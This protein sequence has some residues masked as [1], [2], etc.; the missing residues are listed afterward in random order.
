MEHSKAVTTTLIVNEKFSKNDG[1]RKVDPS[2][3]RSL[4][5]SLMYLTATRPDIMFATSMLSRF[6]NEPSE[7]HMGAVKRVLRYLKGISDLGILYQA[8]SNPRLVAYLDSDWGVSIDDMKSTTGYAFSFGSGVFSWISKKQDIV[9]KS[10]TDAEYI[11]PSAT[12]NQVAWL[13][14]VF[15]DMGFRQ[16]C[17][18]EIMVDY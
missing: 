7:V 3:Y 18:T 5:E 11:A 6:M 14:K 12:A 15:E 2:V 16:D 9:A 13:R 1:Q 8:C 4:V 10:T 17:A